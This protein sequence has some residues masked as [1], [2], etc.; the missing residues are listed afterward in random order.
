MQARK[1]S[2][3]HE[4]AIVL[5]M[6]SFISILSTLFVLYKGMTTPQKYAFNSLW[7]ETHQEILNITLHQTFSKD[8]SLLPKIHLF[9]MTSIGLEL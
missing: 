1:I 6:A 5:E 2:W 4:I 7:F 3:V 9:T 8:S